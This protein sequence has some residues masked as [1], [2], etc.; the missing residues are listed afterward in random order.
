MPSSDLTSDEISARLEALFEGFDEQPTPA[1]MHAAF[2][3]MLRD[4][5]LPADFVNL[6]IFLFRREL[7]RE[8]D[9]GA[10]LFAAA[11][12]DDRLKLLL[13]AFFIPDESVASAIFKGSG[14][15]STFSS[16]I[17]LAYL[18]G[19]VSSSVHRNLHLIR[20]IRNDFAHMS[21][22]I[23]F[24]TESIAGRCRELTYVP[25]AG[26]P[27]RRFM[28]AVMACAGAIDARVRLIGLRATPPCV[29][30]TEQRSPDPQAILQGVGRV[31]EAMKLRPPLDGSDPTEQSALNNSD[32][33][34]K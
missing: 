8:T 12:L 19:L 26:D 6:E 9:R 31:A 34:S 18:L 17:D 21:F 29:P 2:V 28:Q 1:D 14:A 27:R 24:G 11:H 25:L 20:K 32:S 13:Q 7:T 23:A 10:A 22:P 33:E 30:A 3:T 15:L 4:L 16:R 5:G